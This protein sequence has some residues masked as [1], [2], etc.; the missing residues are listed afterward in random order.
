MILGLD[1][2]TSITGITL[3]SS[4][5]NIV[6]NGY[7]DTRKE[8]SF[9]LKG[10]KLRNELRRIIKMCDGDTMECI[11]RVYV[12]ESLQ[13]FHSG[14]SSAKVLAALTA[15]NKLVCWFVYDELAIEP[16]P[17]MATSARKLCGIKIPKGEK[18]KPVVL[19]FVVDTEPGFVVEYTKHGNPKAYFYDMADS[20]VIARAGFN[21][22]NQTKSSES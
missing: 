20:I 8:K 9:F 12:E 18:A 11:D 1:I 7:C 14:R 22:W 5:G 19:K 21:K 15:I 17:L 13:M 2:S 6:Y 16:E 3:L 4:G 10:E